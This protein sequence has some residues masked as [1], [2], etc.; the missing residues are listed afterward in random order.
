MISSRAPKKGTRGSHGDLVQRGGLGLLLLIYRGVCV[1]VCVCVYQSS[2]DVQIN[3]ESMQ[4]GARTEWE[5]FGSVRTQPSLRLCGH[6]PGGH[7]RAI[8]DLFESLRL[9]ATTYL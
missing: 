7:G 8:S 6:G 2:T 1:C 4:P 5:L 3:D 9:F